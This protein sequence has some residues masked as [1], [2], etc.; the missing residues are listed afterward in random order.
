MRSR[1]ARIGTIAIQD[2]H[3]VV[4]SE[5]KGSVGKVFQACRVAIPPALRPA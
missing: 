4:R 3:Y 2:H 5:T 1:R